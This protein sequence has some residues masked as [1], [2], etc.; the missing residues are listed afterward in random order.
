MDNR[1]EFKGK[2]VL[3]AGLGLS[4]QG[5][6][7]ALLA[8]GAIVAAYD[9]KSRDSMDPALVRRL[10]QDNV[11]LFLGET[12][13]PMDRFD[14]L[15]AS[16]GFPPNAPVLAA[17]AAAGV[18]VLGELELA[19]RI[20]QGQYV[21]I[22]G[23]NGK[24]TTTVLTGAIFTAAG[25][26]TEIVGNVGLAVT[27]R[28]LSADPDTWMVTEVSSF[29]LETA[30]T[31]H[32][33]IAALLN[34]TPDHMDRH[35]TM[36]GYAAAK[37]RIFRNQTAAD[38]FV[39]N[40]DDPESWNVAAHCPSA[41]VPFSRSR[42]L[43]FGAFLDEGTIVFRDQAGVQHSICSGDAL[44]IPGAHNLENALAA[45]AIAFVAGIPAAVIGE[46][47]RSFKGVAH[48]LEDAGEVGGVRF[49]NDSK[50][51]N[52]DASIKAL[53]A[54]P[55]P[56]LLI[57]GG[58]DKGSRFETFIGAFQGK[59]KALVL[60]GA[61]ADAIEA[62]ARAAG[63]SPVIR[64]AD[65]EACVRAAYAAAEP[66]DTVLLSPA[67]ASWDMYRCFEDRGDHFKACVEELRQAA[68]GPGGTGHGEKD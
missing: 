36:E 61:T 17:A 60:L 50:G 65:M 55:A 8:C 27:R 44:R 54:I 33:R 12:V 7:E 63:F 4:G 3:V 21:A 30:D 23:T 62:A 11:Q 28:A 41:V 42:A 48:R 66:G 35:G 6:V 51:T 25:Y 40:R 37:A 45:V 52:P 68:Q 49:V 39:V 46:T 15:V 56:I 38:W 67:C 31:F 10:E 57:A 58:Y 16:P 26:P 47:L 19:W 32:P 34:I 53:E 29:Q 64:A 9:R 5:A 20:G 43:A 59:V 2:T 14:A 13:P 24:T 1:H 22:T 18:P